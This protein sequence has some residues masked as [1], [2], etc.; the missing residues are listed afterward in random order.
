VTKPEKS[1]RRAAI[2]TKMTDDDY[3]RLADF[4]FG[5]RQFLE[6]S[7][8]AAR[9]CGLAP[10]QHQALLVIRSLSGTGSASIAD[11]AQRLLCR[12]HT[13]VE[14]VDRLCAL[15]LVRRRADAGDRRRVTLVLTPKA[16][17][18][19]DRL[20]AAHLDEIRRVGP[21]LQALLKI[22]GRPPVRIRESLSSRRTIA[23]K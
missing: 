6:F 19:L 11:V 9:S 3:R 8:R 5:L 16:S 2:A 23:P 12:H 10:S 21:A 15:G 14:L 1:A 17:R 7:A 4:R 13:A 22:F 20:S 18:V